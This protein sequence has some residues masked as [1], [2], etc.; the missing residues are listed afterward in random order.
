[1][2]RSLDGDL[3]DPDLALYPTDVAH[4][5]LNHLVRHAGKGRHVPKSP[6]VGLHAVTYGQK[7]GHIGMVVWLVDDMNEGRTLGGTVTCWAMTDAAVFCEQCL[8]LGNFGR[9]R[10][11]DLSDYDLDFV[12]WRGRRLRFGLRRAGGA[13]EGEKEDR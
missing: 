2:L 1:M 9:R 11:R 7:K 3:F 10:S 6:M 4:D 13:S 8:T 12:D 5:L